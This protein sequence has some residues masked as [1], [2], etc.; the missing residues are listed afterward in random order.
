MLDSVRIPPPTRLRSP[1]NTSY[2]N[3]F[4]DEVSF[5]GVS[6]RTLSSRLGLPIRWDHKHGGFLGGLV[7]FLGNSL[8]RQ[9]SWEWEEA[10]S[11]GIS[12]SGLPTQG[13][14]RLAFGC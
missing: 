12:E 2:F 7:W 11:R 9:L 3:P 1:R 10:G 8:Y 4:L 6:M 14:L 5:S 13:S